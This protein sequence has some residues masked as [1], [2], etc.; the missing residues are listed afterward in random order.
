MKPDKDY[1]H[2]KR[3]NHYINIFLQ[4][5][6]QPARDEMNIIM[7]G[8]SERKIYAHQPNIK[9]F[10]QKCLCVPIPETK[11]TH[12]KLVHLPIYLQKT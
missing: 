4:T 7:R 1:T 2:T 12:K 6:Q 8:E 9:T 11:L 3:D 10:Y 5:R